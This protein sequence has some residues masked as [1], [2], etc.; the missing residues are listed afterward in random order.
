M[1]LMDWIDEKRHPDIKLD[2]RMMGILYHLGIADLEDLEKVTGWPRRRIHRAI[3]LARERANRFVGYSTSPKEVREK[4]RKERDEWIRIRR[5]TYN[6]VNVYSLGDKGFQYILE[7]LEEPVGN[8]KPPSVQVNHFKGLNQILIRLLERGVK[9]EPEWYS[10]KEATKWLY[11]SLKHRGVVYDGQN[12]RYIIQSKRSPWMLNPD[13]LVRFDDGRSYVIEYETGTVTGPKQEQKFTGYLDLSLMEKVQLPPVVFVTP[14]KNVPKL[15]QAMERAVSREEYREFPCRVEFLI[16]AEGEETDFFLSGEREEEER[17][18]V[19]DAP[20]W[21]PTD[22]GRAEVERWKREAEELKKKLEE[23][24]EDA[25]Y[26]AGRVRELSERLKKQEEW[27]KEL[28][29]RLKSK[30]KTRGPYEDFL[31]ENPKPV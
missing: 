1:L 12:D 9:P 20:E 26:W 8:R 23:R 15:K 28:D 10:T 29:R 27:I 4:R 11:H 14:E 19:V 17:E 25:D 30:W 18:V 7:Y 6:G 31:E 24:E 2:E 21:M 5:K 22:E 3:R 13:A 16:F